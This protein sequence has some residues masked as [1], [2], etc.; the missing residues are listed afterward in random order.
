[1]VGGQ[2]PIPYLWACYW[3]GPVPLLVPYLY[4]ATA[5]ALRSRP[6]AV[7]GAST[8]PVAGRIHSPLPLQLPIR[9]QCEPLAR[10][11]SLGYSDTCTRTSI[12]TSTRRRFRIRPR[13]EPTPRPRAKRN[14]NIA[15]APLPPQIQTHIINLILHHNTAHVINLTMGRSLNLLYAH[16]LGLG[17]RPAPRYGHGP[18]PIRRPRCGP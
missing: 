5:T 3:S 17:L 12:G 14:H 13:I 8:G 11:L 7:A 6:V 9:A 16:A 1:M 2:A 10:H 18:S 4:P 15:P